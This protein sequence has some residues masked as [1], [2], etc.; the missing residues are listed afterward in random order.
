MSE[1]KLCFRCKI[2]MQKQILVKEDVIQTIRYICPACEL[3]EE[4]ADVSGSK[5]SAWSALDVLK[6]V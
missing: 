6:E 1:N 4:D 3:I 2:N 5:Y